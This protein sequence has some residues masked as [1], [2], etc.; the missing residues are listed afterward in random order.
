MAAPTVVVCH[1]ELFGRT[2]SGCGGSAGR[3]PHGRRL[4]IYQTH[5]SPHQPHRPVGR[6]DTEPA[7]CVYSISCSPERRGYLFPVQLWL[8]GRRVGWIDR[9]N[10][11]GTASWI[12]AS[13][14][15]PDMREATPTTTLTHQPVL[16]NRPFTRWHGT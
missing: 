12:G 13:E 16:P 15:H 14:N 5:P 9:P 4:G 11:S 2:E 3:R 7:E 8:R 1:L 6:V 10:D